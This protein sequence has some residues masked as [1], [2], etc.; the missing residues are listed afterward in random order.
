MTSKIDVHRCLEVTMPAHAYKVTK[1]DPMTHWYDDYDRS[2][3][4]P[5]ET[6]YLAVVAAVAEETGSPASPSSRT[7]PTPRRCFFC[8]V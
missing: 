6:A 8:P 2:D 3:R 1:R 7:P 5:V 4:G